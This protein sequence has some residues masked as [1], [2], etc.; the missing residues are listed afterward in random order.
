MAGFRLTQAIQ[1]GRGEGV[2]EVESGVGQNL[3]AE[4]QGEAAVQM[5]VEPASAGLP[6][7]G[8]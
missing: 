4:G 5:D 8:G 3:W 6:L 1:V 7:D 2:A